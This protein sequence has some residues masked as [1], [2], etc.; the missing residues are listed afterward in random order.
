MVLVLSSAMSRFSPLLAIALFGVRIFGSD[1]A[2]PFSPFVAVVTVCGDGLGADAAG[3]RGRASFA[4]SAFDAL[5]FPEGVLVADVLPVD[6]LVVVFLVP[7]VFDA[8]L[9]F[10][11]AITSLALG[12]WC[13]CEVI[14]AG[15]PGR[16]PCAC[17]VW[18]PGAKLHLES[19]VR[20]WVGTVRFGW[21]TSGS[22]VRS[23]LADTAKLSPAGPA[24]QGVSI[25]EVAGPDTIGASR[26]GYPRSRSARPANPRA[27]RR[28]APC[29]PLRCSARPLPSCGA[30]WSFARPSAPPEA[31]GRRSRRGCPTVSASS[32]RARRPR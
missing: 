7:V 24:C 12:R 32:P 17:H 26:P 6:V 25:R 31:P 10:F 16:Q 21:A 1:S 27:P 5:E 2:A 13:R 14:P 28:P 4:S 19:S 29:R 18:G 9:S 22:S 23:P 11:S 20:F 15:E 8:V 30:R 3:R